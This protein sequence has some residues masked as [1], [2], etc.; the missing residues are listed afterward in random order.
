MNSP[1]KPGA[2]IK[3]EVPATGS[4]AAEAKVGTKRPITFLDS[5]DSSPERDIKP[6]AATSTTAT[7]LPSSAAPSS[8]PAGA[9]SFASKLAKLDAKSPAKTQVNV[10][11]QAQPKA[12]PPATI[13]KPVS[14][15]KKSV[16]DA[17][18]S[19]EEEAAPVAKGDSGQ[20]VSNQST[21]NK[22]KKSV[23]DLMDS[24]S[25]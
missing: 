13:P 24:D 6:T 4:K 23:F 11:T 3:Q 20:T 16:F 22:P 10:G 9:G 21:Q 25:D 2:E 14:A 15:K 8:K 12:I 1:P 5:S 19:S 17:M 7:T 18:D